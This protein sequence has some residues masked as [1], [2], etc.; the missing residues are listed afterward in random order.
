MFDDLLE[1]S[2]YDTTIPCCDNPKL[3]RI[4][5][6]ADDVESWGVYRCMSCRKD[7]QFFHNRTKVWEVM[8]ARMANRYCKCPCHELKTDCPK[9]KRPL[10][11][12]R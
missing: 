4:G 6:G 2:Q 11:V 8:P 10:Y 1:D 9:C 7:L 12:R 3:Q 5:T